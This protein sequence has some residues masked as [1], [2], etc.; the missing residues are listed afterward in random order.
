MASAMM[1]FRRSP[2]KHISTCLCP[3]EPS[4][5]PCGS[6]NLPRTYLSFYPTYQSTHQSICSF[7]HL[8][9]TLSNTL[10]RS[11]HLPLRCQPRGNRLRTRRS[12]LARLASVVI[13][14]QKPMEGEGVRRLEPL[15]HLV[16]GQRVAP[17]FAPGLVS[18]PCG[19]GL[20]AF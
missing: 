4:D 20:C 9:F 7:M 10:S 12:G 1:V 11:A 5:M 3:A 18:A 8:S 2:G 15:L 13:I 19:L 17:V 6:Q 16:L 14:C